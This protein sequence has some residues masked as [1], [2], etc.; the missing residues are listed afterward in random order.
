MSSDSL[1]MMTLKKSGRH[2]E[3]AHFRCRKRIDE[4]FDFEINCPGAVKSLE[5]EINDYGRL[6]RMVWA[7][8]ALPIHHIATQSA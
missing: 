3:D 7:F 1:N 2:D 5:T 4:V 6:A 8:V